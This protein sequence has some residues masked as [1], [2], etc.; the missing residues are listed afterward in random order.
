MKPAITINIAVNGIQA[1]L[2]FIYTACA[3]T[4]ALDQRILW[5]RNDQYPDIAGIKTVFM[6]R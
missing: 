6:V 2:W 3:I 5:E 4:A 1:P